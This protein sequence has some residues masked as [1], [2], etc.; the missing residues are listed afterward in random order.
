MK[1]YEVVLKFAQPKRHHMLLSF[2]PAGD[3]PG[4]AGEGREEGGREEERK[5]E[6]GRDGGK[7]R[8]IRGD[9]ISGSAD[10]R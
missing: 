2:P 8:W 5:E 3:I 9:N 7:E 6:R 4:L 10:R 1:W